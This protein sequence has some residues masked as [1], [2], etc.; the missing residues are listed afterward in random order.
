M[1]VMNRKYPF[2]DECPNSKTLT[3]LCF[4]LLILLAMLFI[5]QV[6]SN[7]VSSSEKEM[8]P[9]VSRKH[10]ERAEIPP[11][12]FLNDVVYSW[13]NNLKNNIIVT[14]SFFI[15][16]VFV[17]KIGAVLILN[18][19]R[20][21]GLFFLF[22]GWGV[23]FEWFWGFFWNVVGSGPWIYPDS[24]LRYT[25]WEVIPLW[26]LGGL[27]VIQLDKV[28]RERDKRTLLYI[29]LLQILQMLWIVMLSII[30]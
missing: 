25:S 10:L 7:V 29:G 28:I 23:L 1:R 9:Q 14:I 16:K 8:K 4:V 18:W 5:A 24:P 6:P 11:F 27:T 26:G 15:L 17:C 30:V 20:N 3:K 12:L 22:C 21:L 13:L 2:F 19:K